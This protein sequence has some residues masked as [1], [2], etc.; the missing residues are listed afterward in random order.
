MG[1]ARRQTLCNAPRSDPGPAGHEEARRRGAQP[2]PSELGT[3]EVPG[4]GV[5]ERAKRVRLLL[6]TAGSSAPCSL[7]AWRGLF[8]LS[9]FLIVYFFFIFFF[10]KKKQNRAGQNF[11][12]Q[13]RSPCMPPWEAYFFSQLV[14]WQLRASVGL[15]PRCVLVPV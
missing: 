4:W 7:P 13:T 8:F 5:G 1:P 12:K 11:E 15:S 3:N 6:P 10:L 14:V 2:L 9:F